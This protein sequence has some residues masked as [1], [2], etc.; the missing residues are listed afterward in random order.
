MQ[1]MKMAEIS[2][3]YQKHLSMGHTLRLFMTFFL[4]VALMCHWM[5]CAW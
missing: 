2:S 4:F 3:R 5:A 1:L